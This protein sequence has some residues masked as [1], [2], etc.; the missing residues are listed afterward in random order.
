MIL[1]IEAIGLTAMP[2]SA[3]SC[4]VTRRLTMATSGPR[5]SLSICLRASSARILWM[6]AM[7]GVIGVLCLSRA[8]VVERSRA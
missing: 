6:E 4:R 1:T 5:C 3:I 8:A 2:S 7:G